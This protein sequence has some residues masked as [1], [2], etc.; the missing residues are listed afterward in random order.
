LPD[1]ISEEAAAASQAVD[2]FDQLGTDLRDQQ[3][4]A[5]PGDI[6]DEDGGAGAGISITMME[7]WLDRIEGDP[8]YLLR[9]QFAIEERQ[10]M[11]RRPRE[12][13][14]TRPW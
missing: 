9:N 5:S 7:Q 8:A 13:M 6:A 3:E 10:A 12:L 14:E 1:D 11:E 2:R 4:E